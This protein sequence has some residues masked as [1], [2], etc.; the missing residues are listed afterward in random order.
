MK[1]AFLVGYNGTVISVV[2]RA[3]EE[4]RSNGIDL[5]VWASY[6]PD[7]QPDDVAHHLKNADAVFLYVSP[8]HKNYE[9]IESLVRGLKVPVFSIDQEADLSNVER[10]FV[11]R[12]REYYLYGGYENIK[13]LLLFIVSHVGAL[14]IEVPP[15]TE[16]PWD[17][18]YHR[19]TGEKGKVGVLFYRSAYLDGDTEVYDALIEALE[20]RG[21]G[22]VA[23]YS[24]G[25]IGASMMDAS[26]TSII[27]QYFADVDVLINCQSYFLFDS[28]PSTQFPVLQA[29]R[30]YA[31]TEEEWRKGDGIEPM[32]ITVSVALPEVSGTI[33]PV[34]IAGV[35]PQSSATGGVYNKHTPVREQVEYLAA[36][37]EKWVELARKP[38]SEKK[39]AIVLHNAP[40]KGAEAT[41]GAAAGLDS[42]QSVVN[43]LHR[44]KREGYCV[45][46]VPENGEALAQMIM[47]RRAVSEFRWTTAS[48]IVR[49][50]GAVALLDMR[51]YERWFKE[52]PHKVQQE[53][54][55]VWG[56]PVRREGLCLHDDKI[57]IP[58]LRFGNVVV[59]VQP[60]RG[61]MGARCDGS[62]CKILHDP[63]CPPPHQYLAFYRWLEREF[64]A[65]AVIHVGTH[66]SLEFLPGKGVGLSPECYPQIAIGTLPNLYIYTAI[67]PMEGTIAKRRGY[68]TTIDHLPPVL[69]KCELYDDYEK[70][71]QL[72]TEYKRATELREGARAHTLHHQIVE[73]AKRLGLYR[74]EGL[75]EHLHDVLT[76]MEETQ[77]R[78]GLHVIGEPLTGEQMAH[79]ICSMLRYDTSVPS[80]H[81][82]VAGGGGDA[83]DAESRALDAIERVLGGEPAERIA[84][85]SDVKGVLEFASFLGLR[86]E[87]STEREVSGILDGLSGRYIEP[88]LAGSLT[89][90]CFDVLPTGRNLYGV[91]VTR[92]PT[93]AAWL[94]GKSLAERLIQRYM[95][96]H[97]RYP[98]NVGFVLWS[99][100]VYRADGE[101]VCQILYTMGCMP[102][103]DANGKVKGIEVIPLEELKRPRVD[104]TVRISGILRDSCRHIVELLDE[105]ARRVAMLDEDPERNYVRKHTLSLVE[106]GCPMEDASCRVFGT[107]AG[108]Y[109]AGVNYAVYSSAWRKEEELGEVFIDW[110]GYAYGKEAQGKPSHAQLASLLKSVDV[111]YLKKESDEFDILDCCCNF[112]YAG[113]FTAAAKRVSGKSAVPMFGDTR[114]PNQPR[115]RTMKEELERVVRTRLL[116]PAW[117]ESMKRHG[118]KGAQDISKRIT[119]VYGWSATAGIVEKWVYD[120]IFKTFVASEPMR[121]WFEQTNPFAL[122]EMERRLIEAAERGLWSADE[123][124]LER[125]RELYLSMEGIMEERLGPG[126]DYQG[127]NITILT[128]DDVGAW[129]EKVRDIA[130]K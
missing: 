72:L 37:C 25:F 104:C 67:N 101:E 126:G 86:I 99:T 107:K 102:V 117:I 116:N 130:W 112:S 92:V 69:A 58:G 53:M 50:G 21:L 5:T 85:G 74:E 91:D 95:E 13:N 76:L 46:G 39:I 36:R 43:V 100:D 32:S 22:V 106:E 24:Y 12:A 55:D 30:S 118:Y 33:E 8:R 2:E 60:K 87:E 113:G 94:V 128:R 75:I 110:S 89:R 93:R 83:G 44:M 41:V 98:E 19:S 48:E 121:E 23:V 122:E 62:V 115:V 4:I 90:G 16:M 38:N 3:L 123:D 49:G 77:V 51:T 82:C 47:Q 97:G 88:G 42:F 10:G 125:L 68:S 114:D 59:C 57:V 119:H 9:L 20:R 103:W 54:L 28:K 108:A 40:C 27:E 71:E 64:G 15:P 73:I 111:T 129:K 1:V 14:D 84:E 105:A 78:E 124:T 29:I 52:L 6:L 11:E 81:R 80:I 7:T 120:E 56:D 127:G 17:G 96:E 79:M 18:V 45:E 31:L 63:S 65:D 70:L 26:S 34:F 109:G 61:C 66:G 35:R